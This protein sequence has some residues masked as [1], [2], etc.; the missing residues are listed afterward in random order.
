MIGVNN[1]LVDTLNEGT[2]D[3]DRIKTVLML[4]DWPEVKGILKEFYLRNGVERIIETDTGEKALDLF[5]EEQGRIDLVSSDREVFGLQGEEFVAAIRRISPLTTIMMVSGYFPDGNFGEDIY[6]QKAFS[7]KEFQ[8]A[9]RRAQELFRERKSWSKNKIID[10]TSQYMISEVDDR[11]IKLSDW[12][13]DDVNTYLA[14]YC[15]RGL[16]PIL[17]L[18][19]RGHAALVNNTNGFTWV[20]LYTDPIPI[21]TILSAA[22]HIS[23]HEAMHLHNRNGRVS[24][25]YPVQTN[26]KFNTKEILLAENIGKFYT[27]QREVVADSAVAKFRKRNAINKGF[28]NLKQNILDY[29]SNKYPTNLAFLAYLQVVTDESKPYASP[30]MRNQLTQLSHG[31]KDLANKMISKFDRNVQPWYERVVDIYRAIFRSTEVDI[32]SILEFEK[33]NKATPIKPLT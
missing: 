10:F 12:N 7:M 33:H 27:Y 19:P 21:T 4:E 16:F 18:N 11:L 31:Y 24:A 6:L 9:F 20:N 15:E 2:T 25:K 17:M 14:K 23:T 28:V 13:K 32:H 26:L 3:N 30:E 1:G 22:D 5:L 29:Y 8:G